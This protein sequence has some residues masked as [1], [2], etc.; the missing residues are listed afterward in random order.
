MS[1]VSTMRPDPKSAMDALL[2]PTACESH[3]YGEEHHDDWH[4]NEYAQEGQHYNH[5][6]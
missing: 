2:L 5:R 4:A 6:C 3:K 1:E